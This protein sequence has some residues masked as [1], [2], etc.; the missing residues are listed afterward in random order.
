[1]HEQPYFAE[2]IQVSVVFLKFWCRHLKW[3][4]RDQQKQISMHTDGVDSST[5]SSPHKYGHDGKQSTTVHS[6]L[7]FKKITCYLV[8]HLPIS[9]LLTLMFPSV[10]CV[11]LLEQAC[12]LEHC[13]STG[14]DFIAHLYN[15]H[16]F[17]N[18]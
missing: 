15:H 14:M 9:F 17:V 7:I 3:S 2:S 6:N 16:G 5:F 10:S 11:Q 4:G 13:H 12:Y 1:M 18:L 8:Q